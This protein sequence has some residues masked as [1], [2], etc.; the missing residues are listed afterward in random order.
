MNRSGQLLVVARGQAREPKDFS[1]LCCAEETRVD[2]SCTLLLTG[3][4]ISG[5]LVKFS[6]FT[7]IVSQQRMRKSDSEPALLSAS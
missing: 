6:D 5:T 2:L 3:T 7:V 4:L 1:P